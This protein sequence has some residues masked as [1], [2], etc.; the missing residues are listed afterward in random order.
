MS[1]FNNFYGALKMFMGKDTHDFI[2]IESPVNETT[3]KTKKNSFVTIVRIDGFY[4]ITGRDEYQAAAYAVGELLKATF[5]RPGNSIQFV[6]DY[7]KKFTEVHARDN[8]APILSTC[9]RLDVD[10]DDI[11]EEQI[12]ITKKWCTYE[13]LHLAIWTHSDAIDQK[14]A[15]E[16]IKEIEKKHGEYHDILRHVPSPFYME[17]LLNVHESSV[18]T[19][20]ST[21]ESAFYRIKVLDCHEAAH[22]IKR[23]IEP[24]SCSHYWKPILWGDRILPRSHHDHVGNLGAANVMVPRLDVQISRQP[25]EMR[26]GGTFRIGDTYYAS[27]SVDVFPSRITSFQDF[28][29]RVHSAGIRLRVSFTL[30]HGLGLDVTVNGLLNTFLG[31]AHGDNKLFKQAVEDEHT[32]DANGI[33]TEIS[34]QIIMVVKHDDENRLRKDVSSIIKFYQLSGEG[35]LVREIIDPSELH[36][37]S[38]VGTC[39]KNAAVCGYPT[40]YDAANMLPLMRSASFWPQGGVVF[41]NK[42][43]KAWYWQPGSGQQESQMDMIIAKPRQ[44]KSVL[45][46]CIQKA[47]CLKAGNASLPYCVTFD[48][49]KASFGFVD[50]LRDSLPKE[51][52]HLTL[53]HTLTWDADHAMNQLDIQLGL[54]EPHP[55]ERQD[56]I[57]FLMLLISEPGEIKPKEGLSDLVSAVVDEAYRHYADYKNA[58]RYSSYVDPSVDEVINADS[59]LSELVATA[60]PS[61]YELRDALFKKGYIEM[62]NRAQLQAVPVIL[63]LPEVAQ[64]SALINRSFGEGYVSGNLVQYFVTK[65]NAV[66]RDY[67]IFQGATKVDFANARVIALDLQSGCGDNSAAGMKKTALTVLAARYH[68]TRHLYL[69]VDEDIRAFNGIYRGYQERRLREIN[70]VEKRITYDEFHMYSPVWQVVQQIERDQRIA[71]KANMQIC[72]ITH[73]LK[74][75]SDS[76]ISNCT[77]KFIL[78][79]VQENDIT[80]FQNRIGLSETE[81]ELLRGNYLHGPKKEGSSLLYKFDI[82]DGK[83]SQF[84]LFSVGPIELWGYSTTNQDRII[85]QHLYDALG[86]KSALRY[87]AKKFP[88]GT[89]MKELERR[90]FARVDTNDLIDEEERKSQVA[91]LLARDLIKEFNGGAL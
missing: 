88:N 86:R 7:D 30:N 22:E 41:R 77:N 15:S 3:F 91:T 13:S 68:A 87:L 21:L 5:A 24:D 35:D 57:T 38:A 79:A 61:W 26:S 71:G 40:Y 10:M 51:Q 65:V 18:S 73:I 90:M 83:Y 76:I 39:A 36:L 27:L 84:L 58:K 17:T 85:R 44:G 19:F 53:S 78:G 1:F 6:F 66:I 34:L 47:F 72:V 37:T 70:D 31:F 28:I 81:L 14:V 9:K 54:L 42:A 69:K 75:L 64:S 46:N 4:K 33:K 56:I 16:E 52:V 25:H 32:T 67:P 62:A 45:S 12:E 74:D 80:E 49:G 60:D 11:Y 48:I 50:L 82:K 55:K 20:V 89:A 2:D 59:D 43:G 23:E 63:D 29:S 8:F